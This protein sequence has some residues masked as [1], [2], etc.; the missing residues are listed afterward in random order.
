MD[1]LT[2][3]YKVACSFFYFFPASLLVAVYFIG[4]VHEETIGRGVSMAAAF[5]MGG[6]FYHYFSFDNVSALGTAMI[7]FAFAL[8]P[9]G[10]AGFVTP[11]IVF[12][13]SVLKK[14]IK[15]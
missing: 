5:G 2:L 3:E 7:M 14:K 1:L 4:W 12:I 11:M 10:V 15:V 9:I 13:N 6:A 8:V